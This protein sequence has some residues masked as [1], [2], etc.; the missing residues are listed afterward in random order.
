MGA[1]YKSR[2]VLSMAAALQ[3]C[4]QLSEMIKF[5]EG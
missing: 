3:L 4:D 1:N 5:S 2:L